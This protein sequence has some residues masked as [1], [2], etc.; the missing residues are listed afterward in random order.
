[1]TQMFQVKKGFTIRST[2]QVLSS[3]SGFKN[4]YTLASHM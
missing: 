2:F 1:M 4:T 3:K